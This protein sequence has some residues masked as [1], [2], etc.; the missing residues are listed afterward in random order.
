MIIDKLLEFGDSFS[1][2]SAV[3]TLLFTNQI[4]LS[5]VKDVAAGCPLYVVIAIETEVDSALEA[6]TVNFRLRS[7]DSAAIHA[8][9]STA[10]NETGALAE[11]LLTAGKLFVIPLP[12]EGNAYER[13]LGLQAVIAGEAVTAGVATAFITPT[14]PKAW[15][16]YPD[17]QN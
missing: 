2:V 4:D 12:I 11:A 8:T 7:D 5:E 13:F 1:L 16:A 10:H 9:T 6:A 3:G 14:P 17:A 15:Q